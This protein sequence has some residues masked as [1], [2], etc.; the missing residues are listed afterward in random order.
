[1][2]REWL[3]IPDY[4]RLRESEELSER[5]GTG[6]EY[7]DFFEPAIYSDEAE[8]KKR[9]A[10]YK[11]LL[12]DR[13]RDTL[14]GAFYDISIASS[15][16]FIRKYSWEKAEQ[17]VRIAE[18]L[19]VKGVVFHTGLIGGLDGEGYIGNWL[20]RAEELFSVLLDKYSSTELYMENTFEKT[21]SALLRLGERLQCHK[22][23]SLCLDYGHACL[24]E[25]PPEKWVRHM[26]G[27]I[28][29]IHLN[30]NDLCTDGHLVP[31]DGRIDIKQ[32]MLYLE[33]YG[34]NAP[35]LLEVSG[36]EKQKRALEY[37]TAL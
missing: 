37:M 25:T 34:I 32:F 36:I 35:I 24:T 13:S 9:I 10:L 23:F 27:S 26:S 3:I 22:R 1:M 11:G 16:E 7:N 30:D 4:G 21:P 15:D 31:G 33:K 17:S 12:R 18:E 5:Y 6:F 14:H 8:I 2:E 29:H 28:G 19:G 20:D